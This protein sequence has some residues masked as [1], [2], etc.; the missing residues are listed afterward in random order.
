MG[1]NQNH[2]AVTGLVLV[3]CN[4]P[5]ISGAQHWFSCNEDS[6]SSQTIFP[7]M[8]QGVGT[9]DWQEDR[10]AAA[11]SAVR[12]TSGVDQSARERITKAFSNGTL[13]QGGAV[14]NWFFPGATSDSASPCGVSGNLYQK[15]APIIESTLHGTVILEPSFQPVDRRANC[16]PANPSANGSVWRRAACL[17]RPTMPC[18]NDSIPSSNP[19]RCRSSLVARLSCC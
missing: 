1:E 11:E 16:Q 7:T 8:H 2:S 13:I 5:L 6:P 18:L 17:L 12:G 10:A 4:G 19:I 15:V 9:R 3:S 14:S